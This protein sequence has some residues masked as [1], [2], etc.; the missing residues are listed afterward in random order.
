MHIYILPL[1]IHKLTHIIHT[2]TTHAQVQGGFVAV[3]DANGVETLRHSYDSLSRCGRLVTYG[4]HSNVPKTG[5]LSPVAWLKMIYGLLTMP[6]FDPMNMVLESKC[7]LGFN[8]SF[9]SEELELIRSYMEQ[10]VEWIS[11]GQLKI[12]EVTLFDCDD[13]RLAHELIQS[14]KSMGKI[15]I[16]V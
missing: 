7:V 9:F 13:I 16:K 4:F 10:I 5:M 14:G 8:L 12:P 6:K 3:F 15:V 2:A 11:T 1:H